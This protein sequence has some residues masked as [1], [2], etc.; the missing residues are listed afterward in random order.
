MLA[1]VV[2][3]LTLSAERRPAVR[4][5]GHHGSDVPLVRASLRV[6]R[7]N[8]HHCVVC[9]LLR[10]ALGTGGAST[11]VACTAYTPRPSM[12]RI[13]SREIAH[14]AISLTSRNSAPRCY[15]PVNQSCCRRIGRRRLHALGVRSARRRFRISSAD[16]PTTLSCRLRTR[17]LLAQRTSGGWWRLRH[18][19]RLRRVLHYAFAPLRPRLAV[20]RDEDSPPR[21]MN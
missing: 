6:V 21:F 15:T 20:F 5:A 16:S 10:S 3:V 2:S 8:T 9:A 1:L 4:V 12:L 17:T 19:P 7:V 13:D 14:R 18:G 11:R